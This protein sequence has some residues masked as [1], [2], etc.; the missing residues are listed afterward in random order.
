MGEEFIEN[1]P[2]TEM[3]DIDGPEETQKTP[4]F[5][6]PRMFLVAIIGGVLVLVSVLFVLKLPSG[7]ER[8][9]DI[10][11]ASNI[12]QPTSQRDLEKNVAKEAK[13]KES[14]LKK[15]RE[16]DLKEAERQEQAAEK[17]ADAER[18]R[19]EREL[20]KIK[21]TAIYEN[22]TDIQAANILKE[23]SMAHVRFKA[24]TKG[25]YTKI[26]IEDSKVED[27]KNMLA[28]KGLPGGG[29]KGFELFDNAD[30]M[31]VTEFDK[32]IR[33]IRA[34]SGELEKAIIQFD[35][36]ETCKVN[37]V[38]PEQKLFATTQPPVTASILIRRSPGKKITEETVL[39]IIELVSNAVE[40]L[41]PENISVI[42]TGGI[43][44]SKDI[45]RRN[46][47][48]M[49]AAKLIEMRHLAQAAITLNA[50]LMPT[51]NSE[52]GNLTL[53]IQGQLVSQNSLP[54][55]KNI[56]PS[57]TVESVAVEAKTPSAGAALKPDLTYL[58]DWFGFKENYERLLEKKAI[59]QL[60]SILPRYMFKLTVNAEIGMLNKDGL[61]DVKHI[62]S[63]LLIDGTKINVYVDDALKQK[64]IN[65]IQTTTGYVENRDT[66][67]VEVT[68]FAL[69]T[70]QEIA[71]LS[72]KVEVLQQA[73]SQ[74]PPQ[75]RTRIKKTPLFE[76]Q[77]LRLYRRYEQFV[78]YAAGS[79]VL[80]LGGGV[81]LIRRRLKTRS[82]LNAISDIPPDEDSHS[83][84]F[85]TPELADNIIPP[86]EDSQNSDQK[87]VDSTD[88]E[89]ETIAQE[90]SQTEVDSKMI[91]SPTPEP[92]NLTAQSERIVQIILEQNSQMGAFILSSLEEP[93]KSDIIAKLDADVL[94]KIYAV[95]VEFVPGSAKIYQRI[96][97]K[98]LRDLGGRE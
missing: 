52:V 4:F 93:L 17:K 20:K 78:P 90:E 64:A 38:L 42:D 83:T 49:E 91:E 34:I 35:A 69:M 63:S 21:Y 85:M 46:I 18:K 68:D 94:S 75:K 74:F 61:P 10:F 62:S 53:N 15:Q 71:N 65:V 3:S 30:N 59:S 33:F 25:K 31:G 6:K 14:D 41:K 77:F 37:I 58:S 19:Q 76:Y 22:L 55:S 5:T 16:K 56:T 86:E 24:E 92:P 47:K 39:A 12:S 87:I 36:V 2:E 51:L 44:L 57:T 88:S 8:K 29:I 13:K 60:E 81:M 40:N 96:Y 95:K 32:R 84:D 27:A 9:S 97:D 80:I 72:K 82:K 28:I 54:V 89:T 7:S 26:F 23:L 73:Q 66:V 79:V 11:P 43:V 98:L 1:N 50:G 45:G 67:N 48:K 70:P